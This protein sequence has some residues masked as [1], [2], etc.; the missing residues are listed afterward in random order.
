MIFASVS[1]K[2]AYNT[3]CPLIDFDNL[4]QWISGLDSIQALGFHSFRN[5]LHSF[6]VLWQSYGQREIQGN[7]HRGFDSSKDFLLLSKLLQGCKSIQI[8]QDNIQEFL[9]FNQEAVMGWFWTMSRH[10]SWRQYA[11]T[12]VRHKAL[13]QCLQCRHFI[14]FATQALTQPGNTYWV[15]VKTQRFSA[16][17]FW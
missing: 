2:G 4:C 9:L 7:C 17:C 13:E 11:E 6:I 3:A 16:T 12:L 15:K 14:G 10:V 1:L 5:L 8:S